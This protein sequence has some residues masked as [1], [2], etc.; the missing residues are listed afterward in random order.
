MSLQDTLIL[1]EK[2][3]L[4]FESNS[5]EQ[6][7]KA[8]ELLSQLK[9]AMTQFSFLLPGQTSPTTQKELILAREILEIAALLSIR[10]KDEKSFERHIA[11]VK[12][13]YNDL[14]AAL[15]QSARQY[16]LLGLN[17]LRLLANN[18]MGE[19]HTELELISI[20]NMQNIYIKHPLQLEQYIIEGNYNKVYRARADVPAPYYSFFMDKLVNT[21]RDEIADCCEKAYNDLSLNDA[22][23]F[24]LFDS[25]ED[26]QR[27]ASTQEHWIIKE[28]RI[29]F[30][31]NQ[32]KRSKYRQR[33]RYSKFAIDKR[34][35]NVRQGT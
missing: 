15:P 1:F 24:L 7:A 21:L 18:R 5:G 35:S 23:R 8:N 9:I 11:Q 16:M 10:N 34:Q 26:I 31:E 2:L 33:P 4:V 19:F 29:Y 28:N 27:F 14:G 25:V 13:Y 30:K 20:E 32:K 17:L 12:T 6:I 3:K 22:K